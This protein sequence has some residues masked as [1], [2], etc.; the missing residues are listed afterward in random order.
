LPADRVGSP[1]PGEQA[2]DLPIDPSD[3][4][5]EDL[6]DGVWEKPARTRS[7]K[8]TAR[9][10]EPR[11]DSSRSSVAKARKTSFPKDFALDAVEDDV[12]ASED[13]VVIDD[14]G[15]SSGSNNLKPKKR[16]KLSRAAK[17]TADVSASTSRKEPYPS[18]KEFVSVAHPPHPIPDFCEFDPAKKRTVNFIAGYK[19]TSG[20]DK[21]KLDSKSDSG[22]DSEEAVQGC[23]LPPNLGDKSGDD[24]DSGAG[25]GADAKSR[26]P[27]RPPTRFPTP[28]VPA[29]KQPNAPKTQQKKPVKPSDSLQYQCKLSVHAAEID[30]SCLFDS[31]SA[32][33]GYLLEHHP[34]SYNFSRFPQSRRVISSFC[35]RHILRKALVDHT[36][37]N[38][39]KPFESLGGLTPAEAVKR[40]YIDGKQP[41][42]DPEWYEKICQQTPA[43]M[44]RFLSSHQQINSFV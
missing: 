13:V 21:V 11:Q 23:A 28:K 32:S 36:V 12:P 42:H 29:Q 43:H 15:D 14:S 9:P 6:S 24:S 22:S 3:G 16:A 10:R 26:G 39:D 8:S 25:G 1:E 44:I 40:D 7:G 2:Q 4:P 18:K 20:R 34:S 35:D 37:L 19:K 5:D 41:L 27:N 17:I 38:A 30:G 31:L 33:L